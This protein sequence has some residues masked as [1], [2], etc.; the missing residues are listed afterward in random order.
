M[1]INRFLL[2]LGH[3]Q[4]SD[5]KDI[6]AA[7]KKPKR[8]SSVVAAAGEEDARLRIAVLALAYRPIMT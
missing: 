6:L 7:E 1:D 2:I 3:S 4:L 8:L 5:M